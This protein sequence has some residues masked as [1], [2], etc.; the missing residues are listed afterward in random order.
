M[1]LVIPLTFAFSFLFSSSPCATLTEQRHE[2]LFYSKIKTVFNDCAYSGLEEC[3]F[4]T[5]GINL[6]VDKKRNHEEELSKNIS[7]VTGNIV[8]LFKA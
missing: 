6:A 7:Q 3:N 8:R 5:H 2:N 1:W 4:I